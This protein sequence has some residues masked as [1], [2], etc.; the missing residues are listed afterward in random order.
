MSR[1]WAI[2]VG[3]LVLVGGGLGAFLLGKVLG[4]EESA[5]KL[6]ANATEKATKVSVRQLEKKAKRL[7][8]KGGGHADQARQL[9]DQ[10]NDELRFLAEDLSSQGLTATEVA[11][12]LNRVTGQGQDT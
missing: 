11:E 2:L 3:V 8:A 9:R 6:K 12:R 7:E 10:A 4:K 1:F 5:A